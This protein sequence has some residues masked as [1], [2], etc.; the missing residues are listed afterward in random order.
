MMRSLAFGVSG[1]KSHQTRMDIIGNNIANV[2]TTGF[3]AGRAT[4]TEVL[5][6]TQAD[7][8]NA[9]DS[10]GGINP[11]QIGLGASVATV[12][13]IFTDGSLMPTGKN[14]D[15]ALSGNAFFVIGQGNETYYT[16]NGAFEFCQF[17]KDLY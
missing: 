1:L 11:Q 7:A 12:D 3:K 14:T 5:S 15:L 17:F 9:T 13:R 4:F 10:H 2:N 8:S 16:R 6:Q